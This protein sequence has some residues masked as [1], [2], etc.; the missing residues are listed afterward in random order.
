MLPGRP[1][2]QRNRRVKSIR[3]KEAQMTLHSTIARARIPRD[4][5]NDYTAEAAAKRRAF[6]EEQTR[7]KLEHV[8]QY[9][10]S[11][12][13]LPGNVENFIGVAQVPIGLAGP[14]RINGEH[15][16]GDFYVPLATS[17]GTLVASYSRGMRLLSEC[18]GV[19][20]T[21]VEQY[22][23]RS[24]VFICD[25]A[26]QAREFGKWVEEN[27]DAIKAAAETTTRSGKL[28]NIYQYS[29]GPLRHLRFNYTTGDAAGQ[30][31]TG[32]ATFAACEWIKKNHPAASV[33][34][35]LAIW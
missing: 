15:A 7:V 23:Q 5:Q 22:M 25:D 14:L 19:K 9:S 34:S 8:G 13:A 28:Q 31:M 17:E 16:K 24:P 27:F 3:K 32:K 4:K 30:N 20:T 12:S 1:G 6:V 18:G 35:S 26:L 21:V 2:M 29:I 11:P 10:F 33:I